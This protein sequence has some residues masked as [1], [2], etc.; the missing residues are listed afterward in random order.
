MPYMVYNSKSPNLPAF[1]KQ[2]GFKI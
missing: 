1:E 2:E